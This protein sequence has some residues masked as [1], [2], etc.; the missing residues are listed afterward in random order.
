[1]SEPCC[2]P[3]FTQKKLTELGKHSH[4]ILYDSSII[5][6]TLAENIPTQSNTLQPTYIYHTHPTRF[7]STFG[8]TQKLIRFTKACVFIVLAF[9]RDFAKREGPWDV[10]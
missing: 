3:I 1:M 9:Y 6:A 8:R 5:I 10:P 2:G 4:A 7:N